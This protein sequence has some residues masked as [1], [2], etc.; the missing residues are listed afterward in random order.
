MLAQGASMNVIDSFKKK[1]IYNDLKKLGFD[2]V[3]IVT[4]KPS[5]YTCPI[6]YT[7]FEHNN[8]SFYFDFMPSSISGNNLTDFI[9]KKIDYIIGTYKYCRISNDTKLD[10]IEKQ[11]ACRACFESG[12][13][14]YFDSR[15]RD[16]GFYARN[17]L[18]EYY[19]AEDFMKDLHN[20]SLN[21]LISYGSEDL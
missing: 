17:L 3:E 15:H 11:C 19:S 18:F 9:L 21:E 1:A 20:I 13:G 16:F 2:G 6:Y 5:F 4:T 10:F 7:K 12:K 14:L 8:L